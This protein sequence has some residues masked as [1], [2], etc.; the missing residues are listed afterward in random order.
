MDQI[1]FTTLGKRIERIVQEV[2]IKCVQ[3]ARSATV[4]ARDFSVTIADSQCRTVTI[5][6]G[7]PIHTM[8][9]DMALKPI[10]E[11]F[12]DIQPGDCFLNNCPF[13]GNVHH[14][15]YTFCTPIFSGDK[16]IFWLLLRMHNVDVGAPEPTAY[17]PYAKEIYE[18]GL[19]WPCVRV[20]R[21]YEELKDIVRIGLVR[22][23]VP[24]QWY[25]DFAAALG[26]S[27][28]GDQRLR[29]LIE[30]Y[31]D[32][33]VTEFIDEWIEYGRRRM[34]AEIKSLPEGTWE[35]ETWVDPIDF[36]PDGFALNMK[37]TIDH[38]QAAMIVDLRDNPDQV[39]GGINLPEASSIAGPSQGIF[40]SL[41]PTLHHNTGAFERIQFKLREGC[42]CGIP[43]FPAG[44]S[45]STSYL[46]DRLTS[47]AMAIMAQVDPNRGG[48]EGGYI[49]FQEGVFSGQ[50]F[51]AQQR[52]L[53]QP[54]HRGGQLRGGRPRGQGT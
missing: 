36:I 5:Y 32:D 38:E 53:R 1:V 29:D 27:W 12:D 11:L 26:S 47:L 18:E 4:H 8:S 6:G 9:I 33:V 7:L 34:I 43:I 17:L 13:Y 46:T 15:D 10:V 20:A 19:H 21:G 44:T 52:A 42:I 3:S 49:G 23:R 16:I 40:A 30:E 22:I 45:V 37:L 2:T 54:T 39:E 25:G 41:D 51:P 14:A 50:D 35:G 28:I 48:A 24:Q 31:G